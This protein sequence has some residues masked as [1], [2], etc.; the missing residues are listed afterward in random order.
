MRVSIRPVP[1]TSVGRG[2]TYI[3]IAA[4]IYANSSSLKLLFESLRQVSLLNLLLVTSIVAVLLVQVV[5][6]RHQAGLQ[7]RDYLDT[8]P[9][10]RSYP[11]L[12]VVGSAISAIALQW[13]VDIEQL[14]ILLFLVGSYG[15]CG[16]FL[17]PSVW[18]KGLPL[19]SL[20]ACLVAFSSQVG[21]GL[22]MPARMLTAQAVEHLLSAFHIT[23]I[24]SYDI[25]ILE[26]GIARVDVPCSGLKSLGTGTLFL[27]AAT[28]IEGRH[29]GIRWLLVCVSNLFLLLCA[30][31]IRVLLLVI[32]TDVLK[33][34]LLAQILHI[35]LGLI[36]LACAC[37]LSWLML[38][39]VPKQGEGRRAGGV[40]GAGG[41]EKL[42]V[43][44]K[45]VFFTDTL[46]QLAFP[47]SHLKPP[48]PPLL[49]G[50]QLENRCQTQTQLVLQRQF[51]ST[52][53]ASLSAQAGLVIFFVAL[54]LF[55]QLH[56]PPVE[57]PLSIA[58]LD[59]PEQMVSEP[60][61]LTPGERSF[62]DNYPSIVPD[63]QRFVLGNL[64]GSILV[65]ANTT[66]RTYH[67]PELCLLSSGLKINQMEK[68]QLTPAVPARWLSVAD[69][70]YSAA[71]WFQ[72]PKQT[73]DDFL[74]R[75]WSEVTRRQKNWLL[76]SV[77]FDRP[78]SPDSS[79]IRNFTTTIHN[80]I[81]HSLNSEQ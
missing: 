48:Q 26:N 49:R 64:S 3:L 5:R 21:I 66:W 23:A 73:T 30:N 17:A 74:S 24:S 54:A 12:L 55:S 61:P 20:V 67:P 57:Q 31:T 2:S 28:W 34:P 60:I 50:E 68:K 62:F 29:L 70:K 42:S 47:L 46:Y 22:G 69:G 59:W 35:P 71:Y 6:S 65:V 9:V 39:T 32:F 25:I 14:S 81:D 51:S 52:S 19:A 37:G 15:L 7:I 77:L 11:L 58:S 44:G 40:G 4:W 79:E 33:Q 41:E 43:T 53:P 75:L 72:S 80:A 8:T 13:L 27:L 1:L 78:L 56:H 76:V 63:K 36:G 10:L 38:Q 16:L 45:N 18:R